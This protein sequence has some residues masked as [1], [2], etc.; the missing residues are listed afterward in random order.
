MNN[1]FIILGSSPI[2]NEKKIV[3]IFVALTENHFDELIALYVSF[4]FAIE[5]SIDLF[6]TTILK[7]L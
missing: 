6:D 3:G 5:N 2:S 1:I 7:T 4:F